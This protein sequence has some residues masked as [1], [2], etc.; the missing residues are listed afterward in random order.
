MFIIRKQQIDK[1]AEAQKNNFVTMTILFLEKNCS[2]WCQDKTEDEKRHFV[3]SMI[4]FSHKYNIFKEINVQ[5]LTFWK[6]FHNFSIPL[7]ED[8]ASKFDGKNLDEEYR[9]DRFLQT[10]I[11]EKD[12]I[13][14]TLDSDIT[15]LRGCHAR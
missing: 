13:K 6:I 7:S 4:D 10:L 11:S 15:K 9:L 8:M 2:V 12:L 3:E 1:M 5:K 14:I